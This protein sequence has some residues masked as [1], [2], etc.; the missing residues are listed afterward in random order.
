[1]VENKAM[2]WMGNRSNFVWLHPSGWVESQ[3]VAIA[4][5]YQAGWGSVPVTVLGVKTT[6]KHALLWTGSAAAFK[7]LAMP[8]NIPFFGNFF[9]T[10]VSV[11]G[12]TVGYTSDNNN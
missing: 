9:A 4:R 3:A 6:S 5:S 8:V 1:V 7:E 2:M 10:G 12:A 11:T